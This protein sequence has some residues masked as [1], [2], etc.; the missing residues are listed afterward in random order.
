M[1]IKITLVKK[2]WNIWIKNLE[3]ESLAFKIQ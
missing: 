3:R 2:Q 1:I